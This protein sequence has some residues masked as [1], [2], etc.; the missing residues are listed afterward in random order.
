M[1]NNL[2]RNYNDENVFTA[3]GSNLERK[4][5]GFV[6]IPIYYGV[7]EDGRVQ[8]DVESMT[9][10]FQRTIYGIETVID[11]LQELPF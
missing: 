9:E 1:T 11:Q 8:L 5:K 4:L 10:E 3:T 2:S 6:K 7:F